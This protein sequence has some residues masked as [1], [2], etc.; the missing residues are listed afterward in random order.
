[1]S[2]RIF[3]SNGWSL[4]I[5]FKRFS[6]WTLTCFFLPHFCTHDKQTHEYANAWIHTSI[7]SL[8]DSLEVFE[9]A[10]L[11]GFWDRFLVVL[12]HLVDVWLRVKSV[13]AHRRLYGRLWAERFNKTNIQYNPFSIQPWQ[14]M[15]HKFILV[16]NQDCRLYKK[17]GHRHHDVTYCFV[18]FCFEAFCLAY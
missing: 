1:M 11:F 15:K 3:S 17:V 8:Q 16:I 13:T 4:Q 12:Q 7:L 9:G 18:G 2:A 10:G 14:D 5:K 6:E